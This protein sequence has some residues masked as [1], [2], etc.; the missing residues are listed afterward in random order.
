[1]RRTVKSWRIKF[2][3]VHKILFS[4]IFRAQY[5][6]PLKSHLLVDNNINDDGDHDEDNSDNDNDDDGAGDDDGSSNYV[7][8]MKR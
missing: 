4:I 3:A 2:V 1:M 6:K 8:I 7:T 5:P